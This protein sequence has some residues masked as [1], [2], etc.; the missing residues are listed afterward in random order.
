MKRSPALFAAA[1]ALAVGL[2]MGTFLGIAGRTPVVAEVPGR[3]GQ[4]YAVVFQFEEGV[5]EGVAD[6][7]LNYYRQAD[8]SGGSQQLWVTSDDKA[9]TLVRFDLSQHIQPGG[10]VTSATL[11]LRLD[12][13]PSSGL[14]LLCYG[15]EQPW[16]EGEATWREAL[17]GGEQWDGCGASVREDNKVCQVELTRYMDE[18]TLDLTDMVQ[19]WVDN[20]ED[21]HGVLLVGLKWFANVTPK[22]AS[23]NHGVRASRPALKVIYEG[24]PPFTPTPTGTP[25]RTSVPLGWKVITSTLTDWR[26]DNCALKVWAD[27][28]QIKEAGPASMLLLW[29]GTPYTAKLRLVICNTDYQHSIYLNGVL[30]G[31]TPGNPTQPCECNSGP[32]P[33][34][35][36]FAID[37]GLIRN[38]INEI[39][40]TNDGS[41]WD[42]WNAQRGQLVMTGDVTSTTRSNF[43]IGEDADGSPLWG[44]VQL[45]IGYDPDAPTPL[46]ISAA[47]MKEDRTDGLNR[48]AI[49]ANDMGWLLASLDMRLVRLPPYE[50]QARSPSLDVQHD[51]MSLVDYVQA[52]YNV[53]PSRIYVAGFSAGGGIAATV[54]AKYPDVF[55]GVVD[56]AGPTNYGQWK[57]E[58]ADL[59]WDGE[60]AGGFDCD[61]RSSR[62]LARN[63]EHV[64]MR[65]V[66]GTLDEAVNVSHS[67]QLY[68]AV[69][70]FAD[71]VFITR[72]VGH[73]HPISGVSET[74]LEFLSAYSLVEDPRELHIITDESKDYYWL[75]VAKLDPAGSEWRG[76]VRVDAGYDLGSGVIEVTAQDDAPIAGRKPLTVTLDL[77]RMGL[78]STTPYDIEEYDPETGEFLLYPNEMP[79]NGKLAVAVPRNVLGTVR[80]EYVMY[81]A[82]GGELGELRL[83]QGLD[84][85]TR[86]SDTYVTFYS[87]EGPD[88]THE[89]ETSLFLGYDWRRKGLVH[90]DLEGTV[91]GGKVLKGARLTLS[92]LDNLSQPMDVGLYRGLRHWLDSEATWYQ[93]TSSD[94]WEEAGAAGS[95]DRAFYASQAVQAAGPYYLNVKS[96]VQNW[97]DV[98]LSNHG[99]VLEGGGPSSPKYG[100]ASSEYVGDT[101]RRPVLEIWYMDP[102]PTP[103]ATPIYS[104]TPTASPTA[105]GTRTPTPTSTSEA[106][107]TETATAT[108]TATPTATA[109]LSLTWNMITSTVSHG[110]MEIVPDGVNAQSA[111]DQV[112]LVY[113][114]MPETA[115]L[116][117]TS[118]GVKPSRNHTIYLNGQ[119]IAQV[120]DDVYSTCICY[121]SGLAATYTI[122]NPSWIASGPNYVSI[123]NDADVTDGWIGYSATLVVEGYITQTV[124]AE[125]FGFTSSHD[126]STREGMYQL[127]IGYDPS[128]SVP[129]LVSIPGTARGEESKPEALYR[130]MERA[131][132]RG[133]LLVAPNLRR[134][135]SS[136]GGRTASLE[137]QHDVIDAIEY[138]RTHFGVDANRIY[139]SGFSSG[140]GIAA[141]IAA[142]Y[143]NLFA[144]V[145]DWAG[146]T[147]LGEWNQQLSSL[148]N[149]DFGCY[150]SGVANPCPF[151]WQRRSARSMTENLKHVPVAIVH[152]ESDDRVSFEQSEQ[153]YQKMAEYY[154]PEAHDKLFKPH[155]GGH[156]D[157][158][159][160]WEGLDWM[161]G[162]TLNANPTDIMIRADEDKDYYWVTV[163]QRGYLGTFR[164]GWTAVLASYDL[165]TQVIS[166][167]VKDQRAFDG[168]AMPVDVGFDLAAMGFAPYAAYYVQDENLKTGRFDEWQVT[169]SG[170]VTLAVD[171]DELGGVNHRYLISPLPLPEVRTAVFQHGVQPTGY[172]A[173]QDTYVQRDYPDSNHGSEPELKLK[174]GQGIL[175]LLKFDLERISPG[176][177]VKEA[178]L[179]L[180]RTDYN[181]SVEV[182][183]FPML[184]HW[185]EMGATWNEPWTEGVD[186]DPSDEPITSKTVS[187][188]GTHQFNVK[189]VVQA[190][191]NGE[192][193]EEGLL[194]AGPET[195]SGSTNYRFA[196]SQ[197]GDTGMRPMLEIRYSEPTPTPTA[198]PT[199]TPTRTATQTPTVTRTGTLTATRTATRTSTPTATQI[200]SLT[201]TATRIVTPSATQTPTA[202]PTGTRAP[203]AHHIYLPMLLNPQ[204]SVH[205]SQSL[206]RFTWE[207]V[208]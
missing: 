113:Q 102:T 23:S 2:W 168:G 85:G 79:V 32:S 99:L 172:A 136:W 45:P 118:C 82:R 206:G 141:T 55:A 78:N 92:L 68:D 86:V 84:G 105:T 24:A 192:L 17:A 205:G 71:K 95:T 207:K 135:Q 75:R 201:E 189:S 180:H 177:V 9:R 65:I 91:P 54:A 161:A 160:D 176:V 40:I 159:P 20:P 137:N 57:A 33:D 7:Y 184:E 98:P 35:T 142:K 30:I 178:Y 6:T 74:D 183:L 133:W 134:L 158:L 48:F 194:I 165:S 3:S 116:V 64:P 200:A 21:N 47:G 38:G 108:H 59:D 123:T 114:G 171:R 88:E 66:H 167:T 49:Q 193:P 90:F 27:N 122:T 154:A 87:H 129:L 175:S 153:F 10:L 36:E 18:V 162:F 103:T 26:A 42:T 203:V 77:Q 14:D 148:V 13:K 111:E 198:T 204:E 208:R 202:T 97:L 94:P 15:V 199:E 127:P 81:P 190:W 169:T 181:S 143:P 4:E 16:I 188:T 46:L 73:E 100:L 58:R 131:N 155:D 29:E 41:P 60:C 109:T 104:A 120:E 96:L 19:A 150:P 44:A 62:S 39:T 72:T 106:T 130:F 157:A 28:V 174:K 51:V 117:L 173:V 112:M 25:T 132:D 179:S 191:M 166:A 115:R 145:V 107:P 93:A 1:L 170:S 61:R 182:S 156:A 187:G 149:L 147:D 63:L 125:D 34:P 43:V 101:S 50:L 126:G 163:H 11:T 121:S 12:V 195:G 67:Q 128:A 110:C 80:R 56:Y 138:M 185:T 53:D 139:M 186:P 152:G 197:Y 196:S 22:F 89:E 37:P 76:W 146:P 31:S 83:Q 151:E 8:N 164:E 140:G 144:A 119:P 69:A 52:Q 5:Y 124:V 70:G